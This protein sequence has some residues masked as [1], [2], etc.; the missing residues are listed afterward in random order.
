MVFLSPLYENY[1]QA[2]ANKTHLKSK[3]LIRVQLFK[4]KET[5]FHK[6]TTIEFGRKQ[7]QPISICN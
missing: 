4:T 5:Y 2:K 3:T 6:R 7:K 1:F